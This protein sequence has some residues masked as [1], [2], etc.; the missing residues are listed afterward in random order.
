M[1]VDNYKFIF[2]GFEY[3]CHKYTAEED[4]QLVSKLAGSTGNDNATQLKIE[5]NFRNVL[6]KRHDISS[7]AVSG[8]DPSLAAYL[9]PGCPIDTIDQ[10]RCDCCQP[11]IIS[12]TC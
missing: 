8:V 3:T 6:C 4:S 10:T 12:I 5:Q 7:V 2:R 1:I 9:F 11:G